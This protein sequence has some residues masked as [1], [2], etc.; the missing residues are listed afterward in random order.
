MKQ[1]RKPPKYCQGFEDRHGK[2]RWYYRRPGFSRIALPGLPWSPDFMAAYDKAAAGERLEAGLSRSKPGTIAALVASYYRTGDFTGLADSTKTTYRGIL[3]RFRLAH[4][5]KRV[6][7]MEKRH[8]QNIISGMTDTPAAAGNMLRMI[9]LLMRHAVDLGWRGDDP[10][11]GVRKPKRKSGGFLTWE[12]DHIATFTAKHEAGSRAH[13]ALMLLLYTGQRRSDVVRMG[14]QH[15]RSGVLSITQQKTG[16]DV[17]IPL[18]PDL[19][20][21]LDKLPLD[22]LTFLMTAQGKPFVPAGFTNWFRQM[23][24]EAGLPDGLSPHGLRKATCRRLAEA[25]CTAHEIMAISGH[26]SLA[27]VTR[28]TVAASRKDLAARAMLALGK[29]EDDTAT[30]KPAEAV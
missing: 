5:D 21:L 15:V 23:V 3:E 7:H 10:T 22:N 25:G 18:H 20:A 12:E 14:R 19:K 1:M 17:H 26:R 30:V 4:G 13:L 8:V 6:A 9:H 28:Y 27:E 11:Q 2:I 29:T 24:R 16:Q